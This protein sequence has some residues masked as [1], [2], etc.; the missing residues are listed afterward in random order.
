[1]TD[2]L[3]L[4]ILSGE[5]SSELIGAVVDCGAE[6]I[7]FYPIILRQGSTTQPSRRQ[8]APKFE[9]GDLG[10]RRK[11]RRVRGQNQ[12]CGQRSCLD[13]IVGVDGLI[14]LVQACNS[15]L[16]RQRQEELEFKAGWIT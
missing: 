15:T 10:D 9:V 16:G 5:V 8:V 14:V 1:L 6:G 11:P 3:D 2:L 4:R 13:S 12:Q 7:I